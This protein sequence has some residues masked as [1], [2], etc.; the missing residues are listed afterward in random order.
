MNGKKTH[1]NMDPLLMWERAS[2][3]FQ[4]MPAKKQVRTLVTAGILTEKLNL[5]KPYREAFASNESANARHQG[6]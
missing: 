2:R 6:V 5:R 1:S 3:K 4:Q